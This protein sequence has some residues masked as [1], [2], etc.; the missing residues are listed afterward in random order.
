M[1]VIIKVLVDC[2]HGMGI[3]VVCEGVEKPEQ[4]EFLR[5]IRCDFAQG[6]LLGKPC[7]LGA[8]PK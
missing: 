6:Y 4:V 1:G 5:E 2:A 7:A 3:K 8:I